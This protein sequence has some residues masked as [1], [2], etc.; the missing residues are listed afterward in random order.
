[1]IAP[2]MRA[3]RVGLELDGPLEVELLDRVDQPEDAV[4]DEVGLLDVGRQA[5]AD[6]TGDV[7]DQRRVVQ[8][9]P[10]AQPLLTGGLVLPP[11]LGD[12]ALDLG[13]FLIADPGVA[14]AARRRR[15]GVRRR[16][17]SPD[18]DRPSAAAGAPVAVATRPEPSGSGVRTVIT[19]PQPLDAH[20]GVDLGRRER[21]VTE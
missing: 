3:D 16:L 5:Y 18:T 10:L 1:M 12:R 9:Q 20:V 13:A 14:P 2:L 17:R 8:D 4:R 15:L 19:R 11:Q 21:S 6:A 7:L